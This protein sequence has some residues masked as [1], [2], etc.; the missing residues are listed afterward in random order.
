MDIT[1]KEAQPTKELMGTNIQQTNFVNIHKG[2]FNKT[3]VKH[4]WDVSNWSEDF[5]CEEQRWKCIL[6][7]MKPIA[8]S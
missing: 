7:I 4:T 5:K 1:N 3:F 6:I 8:N 2:N